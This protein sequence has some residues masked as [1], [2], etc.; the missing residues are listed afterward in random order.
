MNNILK[1]YEK[2]NSANDLQTVVDILENGGVIVFPTDTV[3]AVGCCAL[4]ERA[5]ERVCRIKTIDPKKNNLSLICHDISTA[6][7]YARVDDNTFK[8]MKRNL[9]GP[10][11][12]ILNTTSRLPRIFRGRKE[13]GL[14]VP[15]CSIARDIAAALSTPIMSASLPYNDNDDIGYLTVPELIA[16]KFG[17]VVDLVVDG[18]EGGTELSTVVDCT[19]GNP[20]LVREGK[21]SLVY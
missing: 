9:P 10:F 21:Q 6:C 19:D 2:G 15:D 12:F 16:E 11:T 7:S 17:S 13:V 14:R 4:K 3:Y 18:G 1:L 8:L 20:V 5:V